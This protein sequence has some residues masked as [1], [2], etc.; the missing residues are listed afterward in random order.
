MLR[1]GPILSDVYRSSVECE[2]FSSSNIIYNG[3]SVTFVAHWKKFFSSHINSYFY[4]INF[5]YWIWTVNDEPQPSQQQQQ[6]QVKL[7]SWC[8]HSTG[9]S[10]RSARCVFSLLVNQRVT[11]CIHPHRSIDRFNFHQQE[12]E[13][14]LQSIHFL[15]LHGFKH[16]FIVTVTE[17]GKDIKISR[18]HL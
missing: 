11:Q 1:S 13:H 17:R 10:R 3:W 5:T 8:Q 2:Y 4:Y 14:L 9:S 16:L 12:S 7:A 18:L 15:P 6:Q